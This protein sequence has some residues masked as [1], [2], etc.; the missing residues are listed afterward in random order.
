M[1]HEKG[2]TRRGKKCPQQNKKNLCYGTN[3][4][5]YLF[6]YN[7]ANLIIIVG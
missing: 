4:I 5:I 6:I 7:G 3:E 1:Q 2:V